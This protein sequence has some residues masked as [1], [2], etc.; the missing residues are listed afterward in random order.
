M[1]KPDENSQLILQIGFKNTYIIIKYM[2]DK[3]TQIRYS[4]R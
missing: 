2:I 4:Q 3:L 1:K